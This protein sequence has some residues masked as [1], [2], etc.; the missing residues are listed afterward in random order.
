M[1]YT[2]EERAKDEATLAPMW[3]L[4]QPTLECLRCACVAPI[5][6]ISGSAVPAALSPYTVWRHP[7]PSYGRSVTLACCSLGM[8]MTEIRHLASVIYNR[9]DKTVN[10]K[11][12]RQK[13]Y[14]SQ[15]LN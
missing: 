2:C 14:I 10:R 6:L 12:K 1:L 13:V 9:T 3:W 4:A 7:G 5:V 8:R 15:M 11:L